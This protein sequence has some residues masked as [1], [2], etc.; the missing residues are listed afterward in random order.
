[1]YNRYDICAGYYHFIRLDLS[2]RDKEYKEKKKKQL[3]RLQYIP[4]VED[5]NFYTITDNAKEIYL[6]LIKQRFI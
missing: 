5:R 1:M 4:S 2:L 6:N 3:E